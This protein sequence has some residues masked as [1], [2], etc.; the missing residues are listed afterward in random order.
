MA[1]PILIV[2]DNPANLRLLS[3]LLGSAGYP[4][5]TATSAE[6]A[7]AALHAEVPS[8]L[9]LDVRLPGMDGLSLTRQ[10]RAD[11]ATRDLVI[12]AV[13]A[14]AMR[15]D[16]EAALAAGCND[17]VTKPIDTRALRELVARYLS[18]PC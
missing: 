10:L 17:F 14:H 18:A 15:G 13:T 5:R 16:R 4:I 11:P 12:I 9:L 3:F 2:D 6:E 7:L 1:A 8:L